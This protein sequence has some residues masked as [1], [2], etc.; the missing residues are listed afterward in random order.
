MAKIQ[1]NSKVYVERGL[2]LARIIGI[3]KEITDSEIVV[4]DINNSNITYTV[5]K[6]KVYLYKI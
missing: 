6:D 4:Q 1:I 2:Y 3:V 5:S